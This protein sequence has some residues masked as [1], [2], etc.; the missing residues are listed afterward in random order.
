MKPRR[1]EWLKALLYTF[2]G[3]VLWST[4]FVIYYRVVIKISPPEVADTSALEWKREPLPG[5]GFSVHHNWLRKSET[6]LWE[7]YLEGKPFERGAAYGNMAKELLYSQ[8]VAFVERLKEMVPDENYIYSLKYFIAWFNRNLDR[9]IP[10]E[11]Q[12]EI[13]GESFFG[14]EEF[15]FIAENYPRMLN[16]HAAHDIGHALVN[17]NLVGCTS[18]A[19]KDEQSADG[20]LL[21][22]RNFDFNM[23]DDF[24]RDKIVMFIHPDSG[25]KHAMITWPGFF[26]VV[27]GMNEKGLTITLNAAP[28]GIP[29]A[30]RTPIS[31]LAREILQYASN[32]EEAIAI[33]EKR[34]TFV[35]ELILVGSAADENAVVIEKTPAETRVYPQNGPRLTCANHYLSGGEKAQKE[36][37]GQFQRTSTAYRYE[38]INALLDDAGILS[39]VLAAGILRDQ[40]GKNHENIGMGNENAI[41]QLYAH[42][43]VIFQPAE[44]KMWV[45]C[46]PYQLGKFICYDLDDVFAQTDSV[47]ISGKEIYNTAFSI[48]EDV[49]LLSPDYRKFTEFQVFRKKI[50]NRLNEKN[51]EEF[52]V[53]ELDGFIALNP[54]LYLGYFLAGQYMQEKKDDTK[55]AYYY[56]LALQK[57]I[58]LQTEIE[59]IEKKYAWVLKRSGK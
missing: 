31:I 10:L 57:N 41:N 22:A 8:E 42:H 40:K 4:A 55:A 16:Y 51:T 30:A 36:N 43:G 45:S 39:P 53:E 33:A 37:A 48:A 46:N 18:F 44:R 5:N 28:S 13:Y 9:H 20:Q 7:V 58:P 29:M 23:G 59:R 52:T 19:V 27:S 24:A 15:S 54:E 21:I 3:M 35:S 25:L 6:G 38:R 11:Y 2:T 50:E 56:D 47:K 12:Q 17:A 1:K 49:F 14:P 34:K 32:I 26:G